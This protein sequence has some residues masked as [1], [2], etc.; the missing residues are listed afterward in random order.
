[1][2]AVFIILFSLSIAAMLFTSPDA[3][4]SAMLNGAT[5]AI[6]LSAKMLAIYAVWMSVLKIAEK[7]GVNAKLSKLFRPLTRRLF[8]NES[9]KA[10]DYISVNIASN[11]LGIGGAA[12]PA[13]INAIKEMDVG[14]GRA[15][16]NMIMLTVISATSIQ[17]LP[18]TVMSL[19]S[20][21][22]SSSPSF[23]II[24]ALIATTVS[25]LTAVLMVWAFVK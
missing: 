17:L 16:K 25:T 5:N 22:G 6:S 7:T 11:L 18:T 2:N 14:D 24:P 3:A 23:I 4:V 10:Y 8:K 20:A 13:A 1:M 12:T 9:E 15:T 21:A 19:M